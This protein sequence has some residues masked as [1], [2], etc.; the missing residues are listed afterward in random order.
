MLVDARGRGPSLRR[1]SCLLPL[2]DES[3]ICRSARTRSSTIAPMMSTPT[4][5]R[6]QKS[7]MPRIG[8]ARLI[9]SSRNAPMAAPQTVP[10]PPEIATPP[11]TAA[12]IACSS[13]PNAGGRA[14]RA[15]ARGVQ[16]AGEA[17]RARRRR[18]TRRGCGGS[19]A[20]R[21][22][23]PRRGRSRSRRA[24]GRC[25]GCAGTRPRRSSTTTAMM[26]RI[27]MPRIRSVPSAAEVR[28]KV[29]RVDPVAA[30]PG[31]VDAAVDVQR[32]EGD[33]ER[34]HLRE[35]DQ[36]AVDRG[37]RSAPKIT[38]REHT[39]MTGMPGTSMNSRPVR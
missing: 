13:H 17:R 11:I 8:S 2:R 15:V 24:R 33:H 39:A 7:S 5:A 34:G 21:R 19:P 25:G 27:G 26:V 29:G 6:C 1:S 31:D 38:R 30:G 10:T 12:P 28:R 3:S 37:P 20:G 35:R 9:V 16:H 22:G 14:D 32:A 23:A 4:T 18:R 36:R